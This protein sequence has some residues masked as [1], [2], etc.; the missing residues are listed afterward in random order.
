MRIFAAADFIVP[1][2]AV[3]RSARKVEK[4]GSG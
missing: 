4:P 3:L 1:E 2:T